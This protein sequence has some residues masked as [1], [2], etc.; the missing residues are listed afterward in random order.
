MSACYQAKSYKKQLTHLVMLPFSK[1]V[2]FYRI[3]LLL[4]IILQYLQIMVILYSCSTQNVKSIRSHLTILEAD[5]D[6]LWHFCY[7]CGILLQLL[8]E[9]QA[10]QPQ[11][12]FW[13]K[14]A[15]MFRLN[16]NLPWYFIALSEFI[17]AK[18]RAIWLLGSQLIFGN[19]INFHLP[20]LHPAK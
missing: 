3:Y 6:F 13:H 16:H 15:Y 1:C 5:V 7:I 20:M 12:Y 19:I 18:R 14:T 2:L 10:N 11:S 9:N 8:M 4:K 17:C